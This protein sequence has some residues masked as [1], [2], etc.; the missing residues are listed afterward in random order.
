M[1]TQENIQFDKHISSKTKLLDFNLKQLWKY[2]DLISLFIKR[3]IITYYK[4]TILGPLWYLISPIISTIIY[5]IVFGNLAHLGTD[6]IPQPLFYFGGTML[7]T[8][9]SECLIKTSNVF[10]TN[11]GIFGKVYF[12]RLTVPIADIIVLIIKL[13]IQ[14]C[15]FAIVYGVY[16][17]KGVPIN[18]SF[19]IIF[20]PLL[21]L[22]LGLLAGGMGLFISSITTKYRDLI[23]V[24]SFLV[25]LVM[26]ATPVVYP[27]SQIPGQM[28]ILFYLNPVSAPIELFR[29]IFFQAGEIPVWNCIYSLLITGLFCFFGLILFRQNEKR[30][31][32]VI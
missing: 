23:M 13:T 9:F 17:Y 30:F 16:L 1:E 6:G 21:V 4:Q 26:Y 11:K 5:M 29:L 18:I 8:F 3:D 32:D 24:L 20:F 2:R 31:V 10:I 15:L 22:W 19:M 28:K 14:F 12:P 25:S 27:L 7:W